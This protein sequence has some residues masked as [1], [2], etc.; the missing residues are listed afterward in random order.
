MKNKF[1][2][3]MERKYVYEKYVSTL[4]NVKK[5]LEEYGIAVIPN[6]L[7]EEEIKDMNN[8]IWDYLEHASSQ[9]KLYK[10]I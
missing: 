7:N 3:Q 10:I 2:K 5:T 1:V 8:G 6:V 4:E 9:K